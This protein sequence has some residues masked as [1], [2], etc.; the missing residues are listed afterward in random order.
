M[1]WE[2]PMVRLVCPVS[3]LIITRSLCYH[4]RWSLHHSTVNE[5]TDFGSS[6]HTSADLLVHHIILID[7]HWVSTRVT[8][9]YCAGSDVQDLRITDL[10]IIVRMRWMIHYLFVASICELNVLYSVNVV[11]VK[12]SKYQINTPNCSINQSINCH[13]ESSSTRELNPLLTRLQGFLRSFL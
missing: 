4:F 5:F 2:T 11:N 7:S 8:E 6:R 12:M 13:F 1:S 10:T 3:P 9:G